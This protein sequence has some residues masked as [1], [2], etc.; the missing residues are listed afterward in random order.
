M[1]ETK[2]KEVVYS[3]VYAALPKHNFLLRIRC[4]CL[5]FAFRLLGFKRKF[6]GF[7]NW[8]SCHKELLVDLGKKARGEN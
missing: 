1:S 4:V 7:Y 6:I 8:E 2:E 5:E 3:V